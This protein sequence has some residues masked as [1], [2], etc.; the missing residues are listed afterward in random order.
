MCTPAAPRRVAVLGCAVVRPTVIPLHLAH[1]QREAVLVCVQ[2]GLEATRTV[3]VFFDDEIDGFPVTALSV[4]EH[5][6]ARHVGR[7]TACE[8]GGIAPAEGQIP[9]LNGHRDGSQTCSGQ[10]WALSLVLHP[11]THT[12]THTHKDGK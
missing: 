11:H 1:F 5:R 2:S 10:E 7:Q 6:V 9:G 8:R 12:H 3:I 4:P